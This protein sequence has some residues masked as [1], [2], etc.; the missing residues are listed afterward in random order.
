MMMYFMSV[1][2]VFVDSVPLSLHV[3]RHRPLPALRVCS[4][5]FRLVFLNAI[6]IVAGGA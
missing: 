2:C 6:R 1:Y 4:I 5:L 3:E